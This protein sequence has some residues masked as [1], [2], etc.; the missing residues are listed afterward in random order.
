VERSNGTLQDRLLKEMRLAGI[1]SIDEANQFLRKGNF[2]EDHNA[3]FAVPAAQDGDA[4]MPA[5]CYDLKSIFCVK[6]ERVLGNDYTIMF[7]KH[8]LQLHRSL[9]IRPKDRITVSVYL[10]GSFKLS[11]RNVTLQFEEVHVR[12]G[13]IVQSK[14]KIISNKPIKPS[15]NSRRWVGGLSPIPSQ[16]RVGEARLAGGK[17]HIEKRN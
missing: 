16:V 15:E 5:D 10:D 14:E 11:I 7:H 12:P 8:L 13:N 4:H 2:I 6:E 17:S 3:K 1:S 9:S